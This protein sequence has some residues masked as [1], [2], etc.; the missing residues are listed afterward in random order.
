MSTLNHLN[1][2]SLIRETEGVAGPIP[3]HQMTPVLLEEERQCY[4]PSLRVGVG[5]GVGDW[6]EEDRLGLFPSDCEEGVR[7]LP[8]DE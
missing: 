3:S 4:L 2:F 7:E 1:I 6:A 8:G 5:V